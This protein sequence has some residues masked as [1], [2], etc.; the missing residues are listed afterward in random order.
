M[1]PQQVASLDESTTEGDSLNDWALLRKA[2]YGSEAALAELFQ[3]HSPMLQQ[4]SYRITRNYH[5]S[6][7]AVQDAL[8]KAYVHIDGFEGKS[9]ITTWLT[10]IVVNQ[11]LMILRKKRRRSETL[12]GLPGDGGTPFELADT[13]ADPETRYLD[14]E[15]ILLLRRA[16]DRLKPSLRN[17]ISLQHMYEKPLKELADE[18]GLSVAAMKSRLTRARRA[19][20]ADIA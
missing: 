9:K 2:R 6:E 16:V 5:D 12:F 13:S 18:V 19:L 14:Y 3:R 11:S 1:S 20:K 15:Q 17:A 4:V 10:R 7:D 8:L